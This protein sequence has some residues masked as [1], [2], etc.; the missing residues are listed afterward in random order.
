V[1]GSVEQHRRLSENHLPDA[2]GVSCWC[3][4]RISTK[5]I[6]IFN[7]L[8]FLLF[9]EG[10]THIKSHIRNPRCY[11]CPLKKPLSSDDRWYTF[12]IRNYRHFSYLSIPLICMSS[13]DP[14]QGTCT[15]PNCCGVHIHTGMDCSDVPSHG[16]KQ[17]GECHIGGWVKLPMK[18]PY[19]G[20]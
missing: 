19:L 1:D 12:D 17:L 4:C 5:I 13:N 2:E 7:D 10:K 3:Y 11:T 16:R 8:C 20:E 18:L 14:F 9:F 6:S 15:A